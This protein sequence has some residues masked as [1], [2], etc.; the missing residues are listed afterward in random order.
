MSQQV[1]QAMF[2]GGC[3]WCMVQPFEE[4]PGILSV[5]SG[6]SGGHTENPTYEEVCSDTTGHAE[7]VHITFDPQVFSY[8]KLL[9]V[10]WRQTD[11]TDAGGQFHDRGESYRPAIFYYT[12]E[13]RVKAE[14]SKAELQASGRFDR[15]IVTE[16]EPAKPFYPAEDYHQGYHHTNKLRYKMYRKGSGRDAFIEQNWTVNK[17]KDELK[18]R[19]TPLQY[20]VTQNNATERAFTGEFYDHKEEG[21]YVDIVSGEPLFSSREKYDSGCGW[22]SF[23]KPLKESAVKELTDTSHFMVRTEVRSTEGDSHLGHVFNDGPGPNGL[24]Y[25]INSASLRFIPRADLEKEGYGEYA[26]WFN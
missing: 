26:S 11:P 4:T 3:F 9:N 23:T 16:I 15:P 21:L 7:V 2:A 17:N 25:C 1:E 6:Y 24:R 22:P 5:V 8:E 10:Y 12:E 18:S 19:L 14:A 13:Q 20:E